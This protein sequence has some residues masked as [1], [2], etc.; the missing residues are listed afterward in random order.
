[1]TEKPK[2]NLLIDFDCVIPNLALMKLSAYL[3]GKGEFVQL[4]QR[5]P[6][7]LDFEPRSFDKIWIS[8]VFSWN[9]ANAEKTKEYY[10][11]LGISCELGGSGISIQSKLPYEIEEL[12]PDYSIYPDD[13]RVVGF[14]QRGCIRKCQFCIVPQKEGRLADN[15]YHPISN[16]LP[17]GRNKILLLDNEFADS[18][19]HDQVLDFCSNN[20]LKLSITQGY[21]V[22]LVTREKA[23]KLAENKPY[24]LKFTTRRLYIAWDYLGIEGWV[25]KGLGILLDYFTP[26]Q[27]MCY[28]L[29]G[30]NTTIEQD[31]YRVKILHENF[32]VMPYIMPYNNRRDIPE[33]NKLRRWVNRRYLNICS[34]EDFQ[35]S[36]WRKAYYN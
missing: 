3:K 14:T 34:F 25:R 2:R 30:F 6:I 9:K 19:H 33:L 4:A 7:T 16:W 27:I 21:D 35:K 18:P 26:R 22:R 36:G 12:V 29:C 31:L 20:K 15:A 13:D 1:M 32:G 11:S 10:E 24:D 23:Q 28:V 17:E 8:T 5:E